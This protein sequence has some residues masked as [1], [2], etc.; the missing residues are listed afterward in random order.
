MSNTVP[1]PATVPP[2]KLKDSDCDYSFV[3]F[4]KDTIFLES[5]S[6]NSRF[7]SHVAYVPAQRMVDGKVEETHLY[8]I[9]PGMKHAKHIAGPLQAP[10]GSTDVTIFGSALT[11]YGIWYLCAFNRNSILVVD[12]TKIDTTPQPIKAL[13]EVPD[14]PSPNDV[15]FDPQDETTL[16]VVGGTFA[17]VLCCYQFSN[18]ARGVVYKVNVKDL[19]ASFVSIQ[20]SGLGTLAGV[21]VVGSTLWLAQLYDVLTQ[22][23]TKTGTSKTPQVAW[24]GNDAQE[25]VWLADNIDVTDEGILLCPAYSTASEKVVSAIMKRGFLVSL[26]LFYYQ[27]STACMRNESFSE[28][29]RDPEVSLSFSNTYVKDGVAPAPL[30]LILFKPVDDDNNNN[31]NKKKATTTTTTTTAHFEVDLVDIRTKNANTIVKDPKTGKVLGERYYFNEQVTHT[32]HLRDADGQGY[33]VCVNF[34]CPRILFLK[35]EPFLAP[36]R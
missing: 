24:K 5:V 10:D 18:S 31:Q 19:D 14:L 20:A 26:V 16:Y 3:E 11:S 34:E 21:E 12:L 1:S 30:R 13:W 8:E 35:E 4:P 36:L 9:S 23:K 29:I 32:G 22:D 6:T 28:A 27:I 7:R 33:L 2:V 17:S 15:C 25:Q